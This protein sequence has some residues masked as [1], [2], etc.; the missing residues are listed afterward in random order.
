MRKDREYWQRLR[1]DRRSNWAAGFAAIAAMAATVSLLGL[2]I[3]GTPY[4]A[5][6]NPLYWLLMLPAIWWVAGLV[7]FERNRV[8]LWKPALAVSLLIA[9]LAVLIAVRRGDWGAEAAG[10]AITLASTAASLFL[11]RNSL[12]AREG[13]AR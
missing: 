10:L 13:P 1:S 4:Q 7:G 2:C 12:V 11:L 9:T 3:E 6:G 5:R 8:R